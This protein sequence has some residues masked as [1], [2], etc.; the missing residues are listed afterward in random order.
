MLVA[1]VE[2][3]LSWPHLPA[4]GRSNALPR[5]QSLQ[6]SLPHF[7]HSL[8]KLLTQD[9]GLAHGG[10]VDEGVGGVIPFLD[11]ELYAQAGDEDHGVFCAAEG[12]RKDARNMR[13]LEGGP[14]WIGCS[15]FRGDLTAIGKL[16][17]NDLNGIF[18][19]T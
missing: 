4:A 19:T 5:L 15:F 2:C 18:S 9:H 6:Q 11:S 13:M 7:L 14:P 16:S 8:S 17:I 10:D 1:V 12:R 3:P